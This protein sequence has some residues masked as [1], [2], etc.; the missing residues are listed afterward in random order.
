MEVCCETDRTVEG[1]IAD[2]AQHVGRRG[3]TLMGL[4]GLKK[5][6][7]VLRSATGTPFAFAGVLSIGLVIVPFVAVMA[8][9]RLAEEPSKRVAPIV[10]TVGLDEEDKLLRGVRAFEEDGVRKVHCHHLDL[11]IGKSR[12][13]FGHLLQTARAFRDTSLT[14]ELLGQSDLNG[15]TLT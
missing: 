5:I 6:G 12:L 4:L 13:E 2:V 11:I 7:A 8:I 1:T 9:I 3:S 14:V 15:T 10:M